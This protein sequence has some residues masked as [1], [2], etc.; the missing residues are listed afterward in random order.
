MRHLSLFSNLFI[1]FVVGLTVH[2]LG[3]KAN[4]TIALFCLSTVLFLLMFIEGELSEKKEEEYKRLLKSNNISFYDE[5][6]ETIKSLEETVEQLKQLKKTLKKKK[7][8][9]AEVAVDCSAENITEATPDTD[10][11]KQSEQ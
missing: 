4:W 5:E 3:V 7:E 8:K 10:K 6:E 1:Y 11:D 2:T 9:K